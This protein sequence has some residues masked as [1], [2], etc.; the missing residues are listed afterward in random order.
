M[1]LLLH[2]LRTDF[3]HLRPWLLAFWATLPVQVLLTNWS[4]LHYEV[5][6]VL[7][8]ILMLLQVLLAALVTVRAVHADAFVGDTV[9]WKTRPLTPVTLLGAKS[10]LVVLGLLLPFTL[11]GAFGWTTGGVSASK[12]PVGIASLWFVMV[13]GLAIVL[14]LAGSSRNLTQLVAGFGGL[15]AVFTATLLLAEKLTQL[16]VFPRSQL[17]IATSSTA[18]ALGWL[19]VWSVLAWTL[20]VKR[21]PM[22]SAVLLGMAV[23]GAVTLKVAWRVDLLG[24]A[25]LP[26]VEMTVVPMSAD[27]P[28]DLV[29]DDQVLW[30]AFRVSGLPTNR[31]V[32]ATSLF[33]SFKAEDG[34]AFRFFHRTQ[35]APLPSRLNL[36]DSPQE[37]DYF[38]RIRSGFP[39]DTLWFGNWIMP[40][41][42]SLPLSTQGEE[43]RIRNDLRG[44]FV[45]DLSLQVCEV[46]HL[47][48]VPL[49]PATLR[50]DDEMSVL[51]RR[52]TADAGGIMVQIEE[53]W[54][55]FLLAPGSEVPGYGRQGGL[56]FVYVLYQPATGEAVVRDPGR[57]GRRYP[58]T[59]AE[60][61]VQQDELR[62]EFP[63]LQT[64]LSGVSV[65]ER[66]DG[67]R[68]HIFDARPV[69]WMH[70]RFDLA[71]F[72][73]R[74]R[75]NPR[76]QRDREINLA[77]LKELRLPENA[78]PEEAAG[79]VLRLEEL[80]WMLEGGGDW[81]LFRE[82]FLALGTDHLDA[83]L[84]RWPIDPRIRSSVG[85]H[86]LGQLAAGQ[87]LPALLQT[88]RRDPGLFW[89]FQQKKWE[90]DA[91]PVLREMLPKFEIPLPAGAL[92]IAAEGAP[93]ELYPVV[94]RRFTLLERGHE[95]VAP[96]LETLPGF[97]FDE[98]V[99]AAW[100]RALVGVVDRPGL[101]VAA[102]R[103]GLPYALDA[104]IEAIDRGQRSYEEDFWSRQLRAVTGYESSPDEKPEAFRDW[105][106]ANW[107]RFT[108]DSNSHGYRLE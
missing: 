36:L 3:R 56:A 51:V 6:F 33:A 46:R 103:L 101:S 17:N 82:K 66:V 41:A 108:Y 78:S 61:A 47:A 58:G 14:A 25:A 38:R 27:D 35:W 53:R 107:G 5:R 45:G 74:M 105:L 21:R 67:A 42:R 83:L 75:G 80:A 4:G 39:S 99:R 48:D 92:A 30:S 11:A 26:E 12:L 65:E 95:M 71:D 7:E 43:V 86:V 85:N 96:V 81:R 98:A 8:V 62:F 64:H 102:A 16:G 1:N 88:L 72:K 29:S 50:L 20:T 94:T 10:L 104:A 19:M 59:Y 52:V 34:T 76:D 23:V 79:Y 18:T 106:L 13:P 24:R 49:K 31:L 57:M 97:A 22:V 15:F 55:A 77:E 44:R 89:L 9:F 60:R 93:P 32:A 91:R 54:S 90:D 69:G 70:K 84:A 63:R 28:G 68:L 40:Y 73:L 100:K 37:G 2:Q 87:H